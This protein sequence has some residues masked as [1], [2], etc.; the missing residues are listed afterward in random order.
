MGGAWAIYLVHLKK[1][2]QDLKFFKRTCFIGDEKMATKLKI[3]MVEKDLTQRD[4]SEKA[5]I[6]ETSISG[7]VR[8]RTS[9]SIEVALKL[10]HVL[11]KSVEEL[12][13]HLIEEWI[14][15]QKK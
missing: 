15:E 7:L 14:K 5:G 2:M 6:S 9:P 10:A 8:G 12:W 4:L 11:E 13:G 3:A 1:D